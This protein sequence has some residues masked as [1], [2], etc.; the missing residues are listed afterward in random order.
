MYLRESTV[1]IYECKPNANGTRAAG[2]AN[3]RADRKARSRK[4]RT[5][6]VSSA[7]SVCEYRGIGRGKRDKDIAKEKTR[8]RITKRERDGERDA[9]CEGAVRKKEAVETKLV[10]DLVIGT[11]AFKSLLYK[12]DSFVFVTQNG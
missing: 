12:L 8:R 2:L 1:S 6:R 5:K 4:L 7:R 11:H 3:L 9:R 10:A